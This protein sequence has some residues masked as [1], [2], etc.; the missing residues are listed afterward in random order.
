MIDFSKRSG[1]SFLLVMTQK[2]QKILTDIFRQDLGIVSC[3][4]TSLEFALV[5][6]ML[7]KNSSFKTI[8]EYAVRFVRKTAKDNL[9]YF[10][11]IFNTL[12]NLNII[13][14][15]FVFES[16][17][18]SFFNFNIQSYKLSTLSLSE[19]FNENILKEKVVILLKNHNQFINKSTSYKDKIFAP[20]YIFELYLLNDLDIPAFMGFLDSPIIATIITPPKNIDKL[21]EFYYHDYRDLTRYTLSYTNNYSIYK[22]VYDK[23]LVNINNSL[24]LFSNLIDE[25]NIDNSL[26]Y[27]NKKRFC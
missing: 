23:T 13:S 5:S 18:S 12:Y 4:I 11:T 17:Y 1:V 25:C 16:I 14:Q 6:I 19:F 9:T 10:R 24:V 22:Y 26:L 21:Q 15:T 20:Q 7:S 27:F 3:T 2:E 8:D